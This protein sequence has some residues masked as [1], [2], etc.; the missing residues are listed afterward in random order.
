[1]D[2]VSTALWICDHS[3]VSWHE[4]HLNRVFWQL[5]TRALTIQRVVL[6]RWLPGRLARHVGDPQDNGGC[7]RIGKFFRGTDKQ[8]RDA[9]P[10]I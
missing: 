4:S 1:M 7:Q 5:G 2:L 9:P 3:G 6:W 8:C 10:A